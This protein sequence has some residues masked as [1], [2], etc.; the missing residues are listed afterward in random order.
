[1][2]E[3]QCCEPAEL[4]EN[5]VPCSTRCVEGGLRTDR[6]QRCVNTGRKKKGKDVPGDDCTGISCTDVPWARAVTQT[7]EMSW[8]PSMFTSSP[9]WTG[10]SMLRPGRSTTHTTPRW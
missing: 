8:E 9:P 4:V 6:E 7:G 5:G 10:S 2:G 1:M 3:K